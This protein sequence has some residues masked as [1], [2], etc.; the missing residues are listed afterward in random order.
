MAYPAGAHVRAETLVYTRNADERQADSLLQIDLITSGSGTHQIMGQ[1]IPC[2]AGDIC[3]INANL[4]H[5]YSVGETGENMTVRRISFD[6]HAVLTAE[7]ACPAGP[8][9]CYGV[10]ADSATTAYAT[11]TV[12]TRAEIEARF[13]AIEVELVERKA[14][15]ES[16]VNAQLALL[17]ITVARYVNCAIKNIPAVASA[18]WTPVS[19]V[20]R[21]INEHYSDSAMTLEGLAEALFISRSHLGRLFRR[22]TGESFSDYLRRV[23]LT[24][25]CRML[26]ESTLT[27]EE[28]AA[29]CGIRDL[30]TFY[31]AFSAFT[32]VTPHQ[33]RTQNN[34][35]K[36]ETAM[37]IL[38][39]ISE[40]LQ[41][42]KAKV[43]KE[44]VARAIEEGV[45]AADILNEGL[46]SGMNIIGEKFETN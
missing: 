5:G 22:I 38:L 29:A 1:G 35:K 3:I 23:R 33:Y 25:A 39:E 31:R 40:N 12:R 43:V 14:E 44:L 16:A 6:P 2:R 19:A 42:G 37:S 20:M 45:P 24:H 8:Q 17:L 4:P 9:F 32:G 26:R 34:Y 15:W 7:A 28:T 11:L 13:N 10:F 27:V 30:A 18:E 46:L 36:G 41:K 21:E